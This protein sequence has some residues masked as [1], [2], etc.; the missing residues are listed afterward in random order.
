MESFERMSLSKIVVKIS[1]TD[2]FCKALSSITDLV[3]EVNLVFSERGIKI[4]SMDTA[5]VSLTQ[6]KISRDF[7]DVYKVN[8]DVII[9]VKLTTLCRILSCMDTEVTLEYDEDFHDKLIILSEDGH[10]FSINILDIESEEMCIPDADYDVEIDVDSAVFQKYIKNL[11]MIGNNLDI[12]SRDE[13][14]YLSSSGSI[15][16]ASFRLNGS[17]LVI[18]DRI[19]ASFA[20]RYVSTFT[21]AS[22]ISKN[23]NIKISEDIPMIVKYEFEKDCFISFYLAPRYDPDDEIED[24]D[25]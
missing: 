12:E 10:R 17:R 14:I 23:T 6:M 5:H 19:K 8:K 3:D 13:E 24:E 4:T 21:K 1:K 18:K 20:L 16:S 15:G 2:V 22:A 9:G 7:F 11:G 25:E